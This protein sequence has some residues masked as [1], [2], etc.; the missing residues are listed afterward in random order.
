MYQN[1]KT[2]NYDGR[3]KNIEKKRKEKT[4]YI[5]DNNLTTTT[6]N[7]YFYFYYEGK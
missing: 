5:E 4:E 6:V 2:Y 1:I 3:M 7:F